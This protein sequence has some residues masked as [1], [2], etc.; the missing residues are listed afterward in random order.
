MSEQCAMLAAATVRTSFEFGRDLSSPWD[1][2]LPAGILL[3]LAWFVV[4][5]YLL[6]CIELGS[7]RAVVLIALRM[8]ALV[9]L[10]AV[11]LQPQ[12][13][14]TRDV[15]DNS[16]VLLLVDTSQSMSEQDITLPTG[17]GPEGRLQ[18]VV[19]ELTDGKLL[20]DLR[21][22]HDVVVYR[23]DKDEE[24][25][26]LAS[27]PKW[28]PATKDA[29][30][31]TAAI[32]AAVQTARWRLGLA[33]CMLLLAIVLAGWFLL[34][35]ARAGVISRGLFV[36]AGL[37]ALIA[38]A[39]L[40]GTFAFG[41]KFGIRTLLAL[42]EPGSAEKR[43]SDRNQ[44][45]LAADLIDW[46]TLLTAQGEDTKVG[47][48]LH[49]ALAKNRTAPVAG[50]LLM[51]D[52]QQT[53]GLALTEAI[54]K[55]QEAQVPVFA[56]GLGKSSAPEYVRLADYSAPAR[57]YQNDPFMITAYLKSQGYAGRTATVTLQQLSR[58]EQTHAEGEDVV[59][60]Q[61]ADVLLGADDD[62]VVPVLF[63][64]DGIDLAGRYAFEL[65]V[66]V[67]GARA[68]SDETKQRLYIDVVARRTRVLLFAGGPSR[69]F[70][71]LRNLLERDKKHIDLD[72]L[73]Q[74]RKHAGSENASYLEKFPEGEE[75]FEYDVL[76]GIDPDWSQLGPGGVAMI[77]T[78]VGDEAGGLI[79]VPGA[80]HAGSVVNSW[81]YDPEYQH[82]RDLYPVHFYDDFEF[83]EEWGQHASKQRSLAFT[84]DGIDATFLQLDDNSVA[85]QQIWTAFGGIYGGQPVKGKKFGA[86][87]YAH[88]Q[89]ELADS[90]GQSP[91]FFAGQFY[92]RGRVFYQASGEM[93]R[94]RRLDEAYFEQFY[95]RLIRHVSTGRL[96]RGSGRGDVLLLE[97]ENY[98]VGDIIP[99]VAQLKDAQRNPYEAESVTMY[100]FGRDG[101]GVPYVLKADPHRKGTFRG[102]WTAGKVQDYRLQLQPPES[103]DSPLSKVVKV[104]TSDREKR[105]PQQN[106]K[107]LK[108]LAE[109]T[110]GRYLTS[111]EDVLG[112]SGDPP[113]VALLEDQTRMTPVAGDVDPVWE[114]AWSRW[115]MFLL[116]GILCFEWLLRR[117]FKLA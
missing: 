19:R 69:E 29:P 9:G 5:M 39:L 106:K 13:R 77:E 82:L 49:A 52:G 87:V 84:R 12:W 4:G 46:Q 59:V 11:Y 96:Y 88:Y 83:P 44:E 114:A 43:E 103:D 64:V 80:V 85:S 31:E 100:V 112:L 47:Q 79:L 48:A 22:V 108:Q 99:V 62:D 32:A 21:K 35:P 20:S 18:R 42:D 73:L 110:G 90:L 91:I 3:L 61:E 51:S 40:A 38:L 36:S 50:I 104:T 16:R 34:R 71:F 10:L 68:G 66:A 26:P 14:A 17:I 105:N 74:S 33:G 78:W 93:W 102:E 81:I 95:T 109:S 56:V 115:M 15:V 30:E 111:I 89:D 76:V 53:A 41:P 70:Q 7:R 116:C 1:W 107:A 65:S 67:K 57:A 37:F 25:T 60:P 27:L 24:P 98:Q 6:D 117:M 97:K 86:T 45:Q 2:M 113:L 63:E 92:G 55:A 72:V 94:L 28:E 101:E 58:D 54:E 75:L 8:L 23:F